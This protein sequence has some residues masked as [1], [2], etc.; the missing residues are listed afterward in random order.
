MHTSC[1]GVRKSREVEKT[2]DRINKE[3]ASSWPCW[4]WEELTVEHSFD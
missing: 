2:D 1:N 3:G 4:G